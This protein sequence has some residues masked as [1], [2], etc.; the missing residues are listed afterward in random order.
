MGP[1]P[2]EPCPPR[3]QVGTHLRV[4]C[5]IC[6]PLGPSSR[7]PRRGAVLLSAEE[8]PWGTCGGGQPGGGRAARQPAAASPAAIYRLLFIHGWPSPLGTF[9][10]RKLPTKVAVDVPEAWAPAH[11][12]K[13]LL[14]LCCLRP[15][16][17]AGDPEITAVCINRGRKR[18]LQRGKGLHCCQN[19]RCKGVTTAAATAAAIAAAVLQGCGFYWS[20]QHGFDCHWPPPLLPAGA[21][22][23]LFRSE[24]AACLALGAL[25][26]CNN[27]DH[28]LQ[29]AKLCADRRWMAGW[30]CV[31]CVLG[32]PPQCGL[33]FTPGAFGAYLQCSC[34]DY[35][36]LQ[37]M[38]LTPG[39]H[40][41]LA[42]CPQACTSHSLL[43]ALLTVMHFTISQL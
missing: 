26:R 2:G 38:A 7:E 13:I 42:I 6:L 22:A 37:P 29:V 33:F 36:F 39:K 5:W 27:H 3:M 21:P 20:L 24:P 25:C 34:I 9:C 31:C 14:L 30:G 4:H 19:C 8:R 1:S 41:A 12:L 28:V 10:T 23:A 43:Y 32:C 17:L 11:R 35:P 40:Q 15:C 18:Q 16:R